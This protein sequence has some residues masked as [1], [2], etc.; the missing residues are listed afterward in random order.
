[1][2]AGASIQGGEIPEKDLKDRDHHHHGGRFE[3][4]R[5]AN[6][7]RTA[8]NKSVRAMA[9]MNHSRHENSYISAD[10]ISLHLAGKGRAGGK[11]DVEYPP[12]Y[13]HHN[14]NKH[15]L[16]ISGPRPGITPIAE[17]PNELLASEK[18]PPPVSTPGTG[19]G[20][21]RSQLGLGLGLK[22]QLEEEP[23]W[24]HVSLVCIFLYFVIFLTVNWMRLGFG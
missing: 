13:K 7:T 3:S 6:S 12:D 19:F 11:A 15:E 16:S 1:M 4:G 10:S 5:I 2:G 21:F 8:T 20:L 22:L 17:S 24:A 18:M 23:D 9:L 14:D